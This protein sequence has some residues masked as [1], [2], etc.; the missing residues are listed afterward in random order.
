MKKYYTTPEYRYRNIKHAYKSLL[1]KLRFKE[2]KKRK[3]RSEVNL[4]FGQRKEK[5]RHDLLFKNYHT[6]N[7]PENFSL[8]ENCES[9]IEFLIKLK[10]SFQKKEKVFVRLKDVKNINYGAIVVLL[11]IMVKFK[12]NNINFNGDFPEDRLSNERLIQSGFFDNLYKRFEA[13]DSYYIAGKNSI[14]THALKNVDSSLSARLIREATK[15]I[16][17]GARRCQGAQRTLIELMQNTNNHAVIGKEGEKH[18]WLSV[19]HIE[20]EDKVSFSFIDYGVG[21][22][23]SLEEKKPGKKFYQWKD[24]II[25]WFNY[26]NNAELLKLIM[27]G[28]FHRI[29]TSRHY[30][31]KGL[32]GIKDALKRKQISNL[33]IITNDVFGNISQ[34][35]YKPLK[36][37]FEG[38]FIYW[39][40]DKT[41]VCTPETLLHSNIA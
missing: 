25:R 33:Y 19:N 39:E 31:G 14:N 16:W 35:D 40:I 12:A 27:D 7:A 4:S 37:N 20:N 8:I 34:D 29:V 17:G 6:I 23:K 18:W 15:S 32:P 30:R 22:F 1:K 24:K 13:K 3:N 41:N 36:N 9:V 5:R 38:T 21:V 26:K 2:Y 11:S 28:E 10:I